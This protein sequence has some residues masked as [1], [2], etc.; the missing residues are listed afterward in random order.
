MPQL[1][2]FLNTYKIW[3]ALGISLYLVFKYLHFRGLRKEFSF[4]TFFIV[5]FF[6]IVIQ[7]LYYFITN[8]QSFSSL[9][10]AFLNFNL[11]NDAFFISIVLNFIISFI[12]SKIYRFSIYHFLDSINLSLITFV[13]IYTF[14]FEDITNNLNSFYL[15]VLL[16][17][18]VLTKKYFISGF[19]SF[20]LVFVTSSFIILQSFSINSLIFY[21]IANTMNALLIFRRNKYMENNFSKDFIEICKQ[22]LLVR[23]AE[24]TKEIEDLEH[25]EPRDMGDSDYIDE[26]MEDLEIENGKINKKFLS[27]VLEKVNRAL[28]RI[29]EGKYGYDQ[30]T[31]QPIDKARL[32]LFPEAEENVR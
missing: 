6:Q 27:V 16:L 3:I 13:L 19:S 29:E 22:K 7:K 4:D 15:L 9:T 8:F 30:K 25:N 24:L 28:K 17:T 18:L 10:E 32:E 20:I 1:L 12:V 11:S 2:L 21:I 14:N 31:G 26:V 5:L 23:K